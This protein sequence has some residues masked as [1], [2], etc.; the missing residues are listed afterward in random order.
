MAPRS[1]SNA[2][3]YT[4]RDNSEAYGCQEAGGQ[5]HRGYKVQLSYL[6]RFKSLLDKEAVSQ[7]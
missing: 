7:A 5:R 6:M 3:K 2:Q 4:W 1:T